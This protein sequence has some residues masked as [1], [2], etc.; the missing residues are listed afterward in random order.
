MVEA[1]FDII[2][3]VTTRFEP[4]S[5]WLLALVLAGN[6]GCSNPLSTREKSAYGVD[7]VGTAA[8]TAIGS[9]PGQTG[10]GAATGDAVGLGA[11]ALIGDTLESQDRLE[12]REQLPGE[13]DR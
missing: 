5:L 8:G 11:G 10:G 6:A 1:R 4:L 9:A 2:V 13:L 12:P 7:S 3:L